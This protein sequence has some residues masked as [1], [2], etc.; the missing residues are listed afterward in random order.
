M[1]IIGEVGSGK[2][3][4]LSAL[5]GDMLY[6]ND[7]DKQTTLLKDVTTVSHRILDRKQSPVVINQSISYVQQ[8]PWIQNKT[9]RENI[10]FG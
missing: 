8:N 4:I 5:I 7:H 9:I 1:C 10:L 3:S 2:S 6:L